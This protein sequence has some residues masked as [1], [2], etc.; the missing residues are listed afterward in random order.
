MTT[1]L[2]IWMTATGPMVMFNNV[3][4]RETCELLAEEHGAKC[5]IGVRSET[6]SQ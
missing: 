1:W 4:D 2:V 6:S 3:K 5:V